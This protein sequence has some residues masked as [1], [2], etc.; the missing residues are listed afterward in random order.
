MGLLFPLDAEIRLFGAA[1]AGPAL[2]KSLSGTARCVRAAC[3]DCGAA[4]MII[5]SAGRQP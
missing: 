3:A 2:W 4:S 5:V 1:D